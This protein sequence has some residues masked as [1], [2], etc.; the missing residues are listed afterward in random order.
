[1]PKKNILMIFPQEFFDDNGSAIQVYSRCKIYTEELGYHV[2]LI[3]YPIGKD[4]N[5]ELVDRYRIKCL[6]I[7][8]KKIKIGPSF[9][10]FY[11]DIFLFLKSFQMMIKNRKKYDLVHT[12]EEGGIIGALI[13]K[14]WGIKHLHEMHSFLPEGL[15]NYNFTKNKVL[16]EISKRIEKFIAKN[17][18]HIIAICPA[19]KENILKIYNKTPVSVIENTVLEEFEEKFNL[20][21]IEAI[22]SK[23]NI[24]PE[25]KI[26]LYTGNFSKQQGIPLLLDAFKVAAAKNPQIILL[27][28]GEV[29]DNI[30]KYKVYTGKM[31]IENRVIF[32]GHK[33]LREMNKYLSLADIL[34]SPRC[35]GTNV[36]L[37]IYQYLKAKKPI[38][39]TNLY[40]HTQV[41][42]PENSLLSDLTPEDMAAKI[43][44]CLNNPQF[45]QSLAEKAFMTYKEKYSYPIF[46]ELNKKVIN[47]LVE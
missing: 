21:D 18:D 22:R 24:K 11:F 5:I 40:T 13:R 26:I 45:C 1:M 47:S 30:K 44:I 43:L 19:I 28:V 6:P 8:P 15:I 27:V 34:I 33:P 41:L 36:P 7:Y 4:I 46:K 29:S 3:I 39:A 10:K 23:L 9:W 20:E 38:V 2:D 17:S 16:L 31:G 42:N 14:I 25:E 12:H 32:T 37:K 35:R